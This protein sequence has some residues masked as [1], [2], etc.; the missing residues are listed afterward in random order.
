MAAY[1]ITSW[2]LGIPER[3]HITVVSK[4][5]V[6]TSENFGLIGIQ[7]GCIPQLKGS[8]SG[9][10]SSGARRRGRTISWHCD[11]SR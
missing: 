3:D 8:T 10:M 9:G 11:K 1:L 7:E 5:S 6:E 2:I 4:G